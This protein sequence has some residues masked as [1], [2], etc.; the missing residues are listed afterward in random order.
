MRAHKKLKKGKNSKQGTTK[1]PEHEKTAMKADQNQGRDH[2]LQSR[3][4]A[5]VHFGAHCTFADCDRKPEKQVAHQVEK[6]VP[7]FS[8]IK[9]LCTIAA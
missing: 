6:G 8:Q 1:M 9:L 3:R 7:T 2:E 4:E 5:E